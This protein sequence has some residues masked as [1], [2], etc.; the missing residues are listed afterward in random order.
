MVG[1]VLLALLSSGFITAATDEAVWAAEYPTWSEVERAR[2]SE[3][4]AKTLVRQ[5]QL[6]IA[7]LTTKAEQAAT[8]ALEKGAK[9]E[10]ADAKFQES[11]MRAD[12]LLQQADTAASAAQESQIRVAQMTVAKSRVGG[13]DLTTALLANPGGAEDLLSRLGFADK[14]AQSS[15]AMFARA[16]R[17]R[18]AALALTNQADVARDERESLRADA[19][20]SLADAQEAADAADAALTT[21]TL[22][23]TELEAQLSVLID[24]RAATERDYTAGEAARAAERK[25]RENAAGPAG[26]VADSGWAKPTSGRISSPFGYRVHPVYGT[27]RLHTGIDLAGGCN[28]PIYA[29]TAGRVVYSGYYGSYGNWILIDHGNGVQTGYAHI[30]NGGRLVS[31]GQVVSAGQMIARTGTTGASTGCHLHFEV[32]PGGR[33]ADPSPFMQNRGIALG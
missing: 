17:D 19:E 31:R 33:A 1:I 12:K 8:I 5:I 23:Q 24:K 2:A 21:Q 29:A 16:V 26:L 27:Y 25:A 9:Y 18:N 32:R 14:I 28:V 13:G 10:D 6:Q 11:A 15:E 20:R 7:A 30:V 22:H 3:N 4:A